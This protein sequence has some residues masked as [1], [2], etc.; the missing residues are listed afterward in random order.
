MQSVCHFLGA[1]PKLFKT[2]L[3]NIKP[4]HLPGFAKKNVK[5]VSQ[6]I[7]P[8]RRFLNLSINTSTLKRKNF[9]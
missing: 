8:K 5:V 2:K 9:S 7:I 1:A 3:F 4:P 6:H